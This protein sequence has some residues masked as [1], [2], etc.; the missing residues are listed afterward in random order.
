MTVLWFT[1]VVSLVVALVA[2]RQGRRT[3]K[4]IAQLTEMHWELKYQQGE[5]RVRMQRITGEAP[6][7]PPQAPAPDRP[8]E[9]F[10]PLSSLAPHRAG[11]RGGDPE[12]R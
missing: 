11:V 8:G 4:R 12:Q 2:W 1:S 5:L 9:S 3:A 6:P 7:P 10:V